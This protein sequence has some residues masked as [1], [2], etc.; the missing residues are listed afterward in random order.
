VKCNTIIVVLLLLITG[1]AYPQGQYRV[2]K[3]LLGEKQIPITEFKRCV[4]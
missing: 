3:D 2:E 1:S 4:R